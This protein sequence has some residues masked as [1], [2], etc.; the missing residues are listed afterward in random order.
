MSAHC[1]LRSNGIMVRRN[2]AFPAAIRSVCILGNETRSNAGLASARTRLLTTHPPANG[3]PRALLPSPHWS[4]FQAFKLRGRGLLSPVTK[5]EYER[6][7]QH[8]CPPLFFPSAPP[9]RALE[10]LEKVTRVFG[11]DTGEG[12]ANS[13]KHGVLNIER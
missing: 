12:P 4:F 7:K 3:A 11:G 2:F 1:K 9:Q 6:R 5:I 13:T 8:V 10:K